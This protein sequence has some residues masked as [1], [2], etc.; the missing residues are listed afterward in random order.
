MLK[1]V[2][3]HFI[4]RCTV[5]FNQSCLGSSKKLNQHGTHLGKLLAFTFTVTIYN[6]I[7]TDPLISVIRPQENNHFELIGG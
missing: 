5:F 6:S 7:A 4:P 3:R 1:M 2:R